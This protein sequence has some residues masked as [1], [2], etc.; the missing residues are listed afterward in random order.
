MEL[1]V[2]RTWPKGP[3]R[4]SPVV[5]KIVGK[6]FEACDA[7]AREKFDPHQH[8]WHETTEGLE[9]IEEEVEVLNA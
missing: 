5:A 3:G 9:L 8:G 4:Q 7:L 6:T 1:Y 2:Y